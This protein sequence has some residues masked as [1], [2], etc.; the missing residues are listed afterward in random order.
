MKTSPSCYLDANFLIAFFLPGHVDEVASK[1]K[2]FQLAT[3]YKHLLISCLA[4]D[5][6]MHKI[7][8]ISNK[9]RPKG[10]PEKKH[11]DFYLYYKRMIDLILMNPQ[12]KLV[13]FENDIEQGAKNAIDNV[14]KYDFAPHDAFHY[15]MMQDLKVIDIVTKDKDFNSIVGL[16]VVTY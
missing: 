1:K 10:F 4:L 6:T 11:K 3:Q 2:M 13:Q 14:Q 9:Q 16:N 5:E 8:T 12:M 15:A 7:C